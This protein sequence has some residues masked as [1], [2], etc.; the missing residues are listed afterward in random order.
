MPDERNWPDAANPGFPT[1]LDKEGPHLIDD[2]HG[3]KRW[4]W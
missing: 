1:S 2:E 4:M 3:I